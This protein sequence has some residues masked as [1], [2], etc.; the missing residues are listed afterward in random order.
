MAFSPSLPRNTALATWA[1]ALEEW[2]AEATRLAQGGAPD[3]DRACA[4]KM[5]LATARYRLSL[6]SA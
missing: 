5:S 1:K 6:V 2:Q 3:S 4:L